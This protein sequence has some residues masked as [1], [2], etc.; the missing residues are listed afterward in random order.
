MIKNAY[1]FFKNSQ[2]A[3]Q[4][5]NKHQYS[6]GLKIQ[7]W[8]PNIGKHTNFMCMHIHNHIMIILLANM[9]THNM[10]RCWGL[11]ACTVCMSLISDL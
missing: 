5:G 10:P 1:I 9:G 8:D 4:V 2:P 6:E 3:E 11:F 7:Y